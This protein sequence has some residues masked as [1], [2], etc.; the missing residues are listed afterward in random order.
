VIEA[1]AAERLVRLRLLLL[2]ALASISDT[3]AYGRHIA[4]IALDGACELAM[5]LAAHQR[6]MDVGNKPFPQLLRELRQELTEWDA[7][8]AQGVS[9]L[10]R[11]RNAVQHEGV[12]PDAVHVPIWASEVERFVY[13]LVKAAFGESLDGV[14]P[15]AAVEDPQ[16][17]QG[18]ERAEQLIAEESYAGSIKESVG[19]FEAALRNFR[20]LQ[21]RSAFRFRGDAFRKLREFQDIKGTIESLEQFLYVTALIGDPGEWLWLETIRRQLHA[22]AEPPTR[23]DAQRALSFALGWILRFESFVARYQDA[24]ER[25]RRMPPRALYGERYETPRVIEISKSARVPYQPRQVAIDVE[26]SEI[27]PEWESAASE[28][29]RRLQEEN[30]T[31][32]DSW[33][34]VRRSGLLEMNVSEDIS[35]RELQSLIRELIAR[36]D[37]VHQE[38][39]ERRHEQ[40]LGE[41]VVAERYMESLKT[42]AQFGSADVTQRY[43][44]DDYWVEIEVDLPK[45]LPPSEVEQEL[46]RLLERKDQLGTRPH[47]YSNR[48]AFVADE[49]APEDVAGLFR[50]AVAAAAAS[51]SERRQG[52]AEREAR[53][54]LALAEAR[55]ELLA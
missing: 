35:G 4:V 38:W 55:R 51:E 24:H 39:L 47:V 49:I 10:R 23:E 28:G 40:T 30:Q 20:S 52:H 45:G 31:V 6:G 1:S 25:A 32:A 33:A 53:I 27:P 41:A 19:V 54:Q 26:L 42:E 15:A 18:L 8:G 21:G 50:D 11:T 46:S 43:D 16:L 12:L 7:V 36:A 17:Q 9:E 44:T 14:S 5:G 13:S 22:D 34:V 2:A 48:L 3:T 29:F 37:T